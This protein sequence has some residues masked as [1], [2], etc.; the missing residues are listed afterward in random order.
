MDQLATEGA[1]ARVK[2]LD[3]GL[4]LVG[5]RW[6]EARPSTWPENFRRLA[7]RWDRKDPQIEPSVLAGLILLSLGQARDRSGR[8]QHPAVIRQ[9]RR[10]SGD[11]VGT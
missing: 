10:L 7:V 5:E 1:G 4:W 3:P 9:V 11:N 2:D 6:Q 8:F